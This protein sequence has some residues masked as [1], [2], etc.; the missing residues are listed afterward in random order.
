MLARR[1]YRL[2][3]REAQGIASDAPVYPLESEDF[4]LSRVL[5][6]RTWYGVN[7]ITLGAHHMFPDFRLKQPPSRPS[8]NLSS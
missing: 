3:K 7:I 5:P 6:P 8:T 4:Q 2:Q 1:C